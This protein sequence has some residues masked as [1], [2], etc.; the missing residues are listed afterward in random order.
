[1]LNEN[2]SILHIWF[3]KNNSTDCDR[4][5]SMNGKC[6]RILTCL[7]PIY[8]TGKTNATTEY[9]SSTKQNPFKG[10]LMPTDEP[11]DISIDDCTRAN[12]RKLL[13]IGIHN[14]KIIIYRWKK[15]K[16]NINPML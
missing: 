1:M 5:V 16:K 2:H 13:R 8:I 7:I 6:K 10:V 4:S 14:N 11:E 9:T 3:S 12:C 15:F